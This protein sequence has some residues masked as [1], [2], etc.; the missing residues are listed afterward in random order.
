[1]S[2][3]GIRAQDLTWAEINFESPEQAFKFA[4]KLERLAKDPRISAEDLVK[5]ETA[6]D[7]IFATLFDF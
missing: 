1:M 7:D 3:H 6:L 5:I 4:S 2:T